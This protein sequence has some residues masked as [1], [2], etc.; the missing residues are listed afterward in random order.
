MGTGIEREA[1]K[2]RDSDSREGRGERERERERE[3]CKI[4]LC[5]AACET[6]F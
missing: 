4:Y 1:G 5:Y 3:R 6:D 2:E